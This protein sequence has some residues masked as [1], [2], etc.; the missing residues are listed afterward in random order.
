MSGG[1]ET[2]AG[3]AEELVVLAGEY[4]L[5]TLCREEARLLEREAETDPVVAGAIAGWEQAL[6]PLLE[7]VTSVAPPPTVWPRIQST[8]DFAGPVRPAAPTGALPGNRLAAAG[9]DPASAV[10]GSPNRPANSNIWRAAAAAGFL[11]AAGIAGVAILDR[12]AGVPVPVAALSPVGSK[13][14]VFVAES[15]PNGSLSIVPLSPVDVASG[16]DLELWSLRRGETVPHPLGVMQ[17]TGTRLAA[18]TLPHG[19]LQLLIS[20]EPKGG[21]PTGLPTGPVLWGAFL[22][23]SR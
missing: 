5:G 22:P 12:P 21:S 2:G 17:P 10:T 4:V 11:L 19:D 18:G 7:T 1:I 3:P 20:L 9:T 15:Q 6:A 16:H 13:P 8:L 14:A 23:Q